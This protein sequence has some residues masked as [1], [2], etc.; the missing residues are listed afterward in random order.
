MSINHHYLMLKQ[1]HPANKANLT[2]KY[3]KE[4]E[5]R[6]REAA[7]KVELEK[8]RERYLFD[9]V[10]DRIQII[11]QMVEMRDHGKE[12]NPREMELDFM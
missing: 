4:Q 7:A 2:K 3:E 12:L 6:K 1:W 11:E 9:K 8:R 5:V 10:V